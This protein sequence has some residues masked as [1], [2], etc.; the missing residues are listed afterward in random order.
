MASDRV[1]YR[2]T[3]FAI[4]T[5]LRSKM[6]RLAKWTDVNFQERTLTIPNAN[7]KTKGRGDHTVFLSA[8]ALQI[9]NGM[10]RYPGIDLI[11]PSPR[12]NE[13]FLM[14]QWGLSLP[15]CTNEV[16]KVAGRDGLIPCYLK[17]RGIGD[18]DTAWNFSCKF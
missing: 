3:A 7:F 15:D 17:G 12:Q 2:M 14:R 11:F 8:A 18:C 1:S 6:V 10:P 4:L 13:N 9:L 5:T 16:F